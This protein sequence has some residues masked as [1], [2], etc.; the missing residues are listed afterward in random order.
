M[1]FSKLN[2]AI[3]DNLSTQAEQKE[4]VLE[5]VKKQ[6]KELEDWANRFRELTQDARQFG[7]VLRNAKSTAGLDKAL[8]V[9]S[10]VGFISIRDNYYMNASYEPKEIKV[11]FKRR[12]NDY[13]TSWS[14]I[15]EDETLP[16]R[17]VE[18]SFATDLNDTKNLIYDTSRCE[19]PTPLSD[20]TT[21]RDINTRNRIT[22][23]LL[24]IRS[25]SPEKA[26]D[27]YIQSTVDIA[28]SIINTLKAKNEE[29]AKLIE[30]ANRELEM[31][32]KK[33]PSV[34]E[35]EDGTVEIRLGGKTY[36]AT[37]KEEVNNAENS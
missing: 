35:L 4:Q 30:K 20:L 36:S 9:N 31:Q 29:L 15:L 17:P 26:A 18:C 22:L 5:I 12:I 16:I 25:I 6:C 32:E 21:L 10:D 7:L 13:E 3:E 27:E 1:D 34:K 33:S 19:F 24:I 14:F 11:S 28:Y 23:D 8:I 37:L 2:K